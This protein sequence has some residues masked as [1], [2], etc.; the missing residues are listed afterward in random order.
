MK[1]KRHTAE[2]IVGKLRQAQMEIGKGARVDQVAR[3]LGVN[4]QT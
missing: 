4:E 1:K 2:Q 3:K